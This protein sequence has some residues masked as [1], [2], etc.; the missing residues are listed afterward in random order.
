MKEKRGSIA[1]FAT[2]RPP[3]QLDLYSCP[4]PPTSK[5][6]EVCL[7]DGKS[8]NYNGQVIPPAALKKI[9]TR[10]NPKLQ[11]LK[12]TD[13]DV[14]S[15][16]V[17]GMIF[18]SERTDN[19]ET[20]H[21]SI[22]FNGNFQV[23]NFADV[24]DTFKGV[25]MED[26]P[27]FAGVDR[28]YLIYVTTKDNPIKDDPKKD[29]VTKRRQP[30]TA[31]YRTHL[32]DGTTQ[33]LTP[34]G[35]ADLNPS[36][37][38]SGRKIAVASFLATP[39][40]G[41]IENLKTGIFVIDISN[42]TSAKRKYV[43]KEGG[44]PTWANENVIFFHKKEE[45]KNWG[46]YQ[47]DINKSRSQE[48]PSVTPHNIDAITP[49]AISATK[50]AVATMRKKS[51]FNDVRDVDQYRHIEIFDV[52]LGKETSLKITQ[53]TRPKADHYNPFVIDKNNNGMK[54]IG[55]HRCKTE[56]LK[57]IEHIS[58]KS[59]K[60]LSPHPEVGL[61]RVGGVFP[62]FSSDGTKLAFI[63]NEFKNVW[64]ADDKGLRIVYASEKINSFFSPIWNKNP[65]KD[66]LYLCMGE[67]FAAK[68][69]VD[70][71][72]LP[73]VSSG[74][75]D[76]V[77]LT[78]GHN[79]AFPST[80]ADGTRLVFRSTRH[81]GD[82][83][84]RNLYI[85]EDT[86]IGEFEGGEITRLTNG[87]W[88]DSHCE[89]SPKGDW[90]V[91]SSNRDK[92]KEASKK[93][94]ATL[95]QGCYAVYLVNLDH[96]DTVIRVVT[97]AS[98][99]AGHVNHPYFSPDAKSIVFVSDLAAV[100]VDPISLP[101]FIHSLRPYGDIFSVEIK[102]AYDIELDGKSKKIELDI[103]DFTRVT[104]TRYENSTA[105][106]TRFATDDPKAAWN[107]L[108]KDHPSGPLTSHGPTHE[109]ERAECPLIMGHLSVG[110]KT[111]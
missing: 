21:F 59:H 24:Y 41:E 69:T 26:N 98:D 60:I 111:C 76:G 9:L 107:L 57:G 66:T 14:D 19:L 44:W 8:Y 72:A 99:I 64:L 62:S 54:R 17:T 10:P 12:A 58:R 45:G 34:K 104:H 93:D 106:W 46:V 43:L 102:Q 96:R 82:K 88:F 56:F 37:S 47:A 1:F 65:E 36:V 89:W 40:K 18:V 110:R 38:P 73:N 16:R 81:G 94:K 70:I 71:Y 50:V 2:Y 108:L 32:L 11:A 29:D 87:E 103:Q 30:W 109:Y 28:E 35:E 67:S 6:D 79:N 105:T 86:E 25:R 3:V 5:K 100:S 7:T 91:F 13:D 80:N 74:N 97:S 27:C 42:P 68:G 48:T 85:M 101:F 51:G 39:W 33:R 53:N 63:D 90:I 78:D 95:D 4:I 83:L 52:T 77:M 49:V 31:V 75:Q 15:G 23:F 22:C 61:F 55:Y 92:T 20:L 84:Y